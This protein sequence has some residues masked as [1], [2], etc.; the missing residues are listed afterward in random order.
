[1]PELPFKLPKSVSSYVEQF[2][3]HPQ[4]TITRFKKQLK[5][6]GSDAI[7]YFVLGWFYYKQNDRDKAINC[8]LKAKTLAPGS[9]FFEK[10]HFYFSHPQLFDARYIPTSAGSLNQLDYDAGNNLDSLIKKISQLDSTHI[11][12][13]VQQDDAPSAPRTYNEEQTDD[14][15]S[16]TLADVHKRQGN[17]AEAIRVYEMLKSSKKEKADIYDEQIKELKKLQAEERK[18]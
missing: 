6:R 18:N 3:D 14:I 11:R 9:P 16:E 2:D 4:K 15:V 5:R 8:A 1:M 10:L 7:G 12:M 17:L 13:D